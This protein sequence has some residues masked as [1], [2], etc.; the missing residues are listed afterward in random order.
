MGCVGESGAVPDA[1]VSVL[2]VIPS[3]DVVRSER[4]AHTECTQKRESGAADALEFE[5]ERQVV[6]LPADRVAVEYLKKVKEEL[7][8]VPHEELGE[9]VVVDGLVDTDPSFS[10]VPELGAISRVRVVHQVVMEQVA[11]AGD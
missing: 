11:A 4:V 9:D 10:E 2:Q 6:P 8:P 7:A 1:S 5:E 3:V